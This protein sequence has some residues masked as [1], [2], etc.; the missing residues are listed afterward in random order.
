[1]K[2]NKFASK[3]LALLVTSAMTIPA[4]ANK[5]DKVTLLETPV[6]ISEIS[7]ID[8]FIGDRLKLN[9]DVYLKNFPIDKYVDFVVNRQHTAWDWTKAEQHGKWIESAYLSAIQGKDKELYQKVKKELYRIIA[10][11]EPNGYFHG[12]DCCTASSHRIIS[13]LPTFFYAE[14]GKEFYVNQYVDANYDGK[15]FQ[16]SITGNYPAGETVEL[17][18]NK[19]ANKELNLRILSW[20]NNPS[21]SLNG[22]TLTGVNPGSYYKINRVWK[23]GDKLTI[24]FP[25]EER[26]V[27]R[28][29]HNN[30]EMRMLPG[31]EIMYDP[32]PTP[33]IPYAY[34]RG[35][36][37]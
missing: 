1:M 18:I 7:G 22:K 31:G 17:T 28:E 6:K 9:R 19:E 5:N 23:K 12:P 34:L 36:V 29:N 16:F 8:G 26:W 11:Q 10:S 14:E 30:Y 37:V 20:C 21:I 33:T 2:M 24:H 3:A 13:L 32:K 15:G 4:L 35:P 27:K 25:M